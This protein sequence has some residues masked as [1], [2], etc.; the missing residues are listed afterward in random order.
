MITKN[1]GGLKMTEIRFCG[2]G[3]QGIVRCALISGKAFSIFENKY[4]TM[5]QS[6]GPEARGGGVQFST[7]AF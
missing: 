2:Y 4:A 5:T 7:G 3:G 1:M 6:F